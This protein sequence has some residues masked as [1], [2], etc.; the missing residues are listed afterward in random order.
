M[1]DPS[2]TAAIEAQA[3]LGDDRRPLDWNGPVDRPFTP[4]AVQ[5]LDCPVI[6][7]LERVARRQPDH[8]A[9]TDAQTSLTYRQLWD[10]LS[11]LAQTIAAETRPGELVGILMPASPGRVSAAMVSARPERPSHSWP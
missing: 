7:L 10:G 1:R 5:D 9:V 3:W 11:G 8:L 4:F 6:D 2:T